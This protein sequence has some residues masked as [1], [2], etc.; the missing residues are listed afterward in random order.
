MCIVHMYVANLHTYKKLAARVLPTWPIQG[1]Q[2]QV[3]YGV[4]REVKGGGETPHAWTLG[5]I[6]MDAASP[7]NSICSSGCTLAYVTK[8]TMQR[9]C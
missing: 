4:I 8:I 3:N 7:S 6:K 1:R 5:C 2:K 9:L